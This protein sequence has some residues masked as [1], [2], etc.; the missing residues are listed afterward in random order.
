[1]LPCGR[2]RRAA[3]AVVARLDCIDRQIDALLCPRVF[4]NSIARE[5]TCHELPIAQRASGQIVKKRVPYPTDQLSGVRLPRRSGKVD[6]HIASKPVKR[7]ERE[8]S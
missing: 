8:Q 6:P 3:V 1:M 4:D 2:P 5:R 7:M